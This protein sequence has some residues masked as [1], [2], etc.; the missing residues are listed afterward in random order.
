[1][2]NLT[3]IVLSAQNGQLVD[4][5]ADRYGLT[6]EQIESAIDALIPAISAGLTH[7]AAEP[8]SLEK[9][10]AGAASPQHL[11]AYDAGDHSDESIEQ[12]HKIVA[13]L[14]GSTAEAN[15][16]AQVAARAAGLRPDIMAQLMPVLVSVVLGGLF[17]GAGA[18]GLGG[19]LGQL[20][21]SGSLGQIIGQLAGGGALG[22]V[23]GNVLGG[24]LGGGAPQQQAP[25]PQPQA[26]GLGGLL[27][28]L[29][30][31]LLGGGRP[32][33]QSAARPAPEPSMKGP[34]GL[35]D[36]LDSAELQATLEQIKKTLQPGGAGANAAHH[37]DLQDVLG[38]ILA[39]R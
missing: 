15:Q 27:G 17:K 28:G 33:P 12:G 23:L 16:M 34:A 18:G 19:V 1:M 29:L 10:I 2:S 25:A 31:A 36:G 5:L 14:F 26:G 13:H 24:A 20:A 30:G 4:N 21:S 35:P 9:I 7:A 37:S 32:A 22:G 6:R 3:D 39:R 8:A 11:A 38:Q